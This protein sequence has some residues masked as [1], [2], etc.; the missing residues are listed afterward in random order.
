MPIYGASTAHPGFWGEHGIWYQGL[1]LGPLH[2]PDRCLSHQAISS[3]Q[4]N[5]FHV[6]ISFFFLSARNLNPGP[7]NT[8]NF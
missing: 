8:L 3:G 1:D 7:C 6:L 2:L 4:Q 5:I